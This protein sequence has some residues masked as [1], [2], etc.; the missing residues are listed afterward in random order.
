MIVDAVSV[1][2]EVFGPYMDASILGRAR[3]AGDRKSVG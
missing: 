2:P 1:V 3:R